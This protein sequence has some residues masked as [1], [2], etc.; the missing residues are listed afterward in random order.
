M[1][2]KN[3]NSQWG[4]PV[5]FE[6]VE[7]MVEAIRECGFEGCDDLKPDDLEEGVDYEII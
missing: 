1:K 2:I 6:T 4:D 5:E 7:E 3:I